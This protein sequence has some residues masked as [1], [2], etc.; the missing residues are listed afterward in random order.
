MLSIISWGEDSVKRLWGGYRLD[1]Q[2]VL[3]VLQHKNVQGGV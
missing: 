2:V 3:A 1:F